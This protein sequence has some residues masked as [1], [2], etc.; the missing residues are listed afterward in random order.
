LTSAVRSL[1]STVLLKCS[2]RIADARNILGVVALCA[3]LGSLIDIGAFGDD[4]HDAAQI[5][6]QL[7]SEWSGN[8]VAFFS[9][10]QA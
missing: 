7:L 9:S 3:T 1:R 8:A 5:V 4:E 6:E 2:H 10:S